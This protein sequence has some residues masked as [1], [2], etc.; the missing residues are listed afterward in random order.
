[1]LPAFLAD[2]TDFDAAAAW[3]ALASSAFCSCIISNNSLTRSCC[4]AR[5]SPVSKSH[6]STTA[7]AAFIVLSGLLYL[8]FSTMLKDAEVLFPAR[9]SRRRS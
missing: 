6:I 7:L 9:T 4:F 3:F 1:L 5:A 2:R 8:G